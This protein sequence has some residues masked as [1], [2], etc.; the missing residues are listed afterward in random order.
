MRLLG[1]ENHHERVLSFKEERKYLEAAADLGHQL[2]DGYARALQGI[3][4]VKRGEQPRQPDAYLLRDVATLLID[5]ALRP[6]NA[7]V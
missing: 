7:S 5:C 2:T 4:A 1:G 6:K 3:R